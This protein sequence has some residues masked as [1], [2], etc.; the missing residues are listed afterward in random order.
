MTYNN[1]L[2]QLALRSTTVLFNFSTLNF[3]TSNSSTFLSSFELFNF[4]LLNLFS[5]LWSNPEASDRLVPITDHRP[6]LPSLSFPLELFNF[7]LL[8]LFSLLWSDA[9]WQ[10]P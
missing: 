10:I 4:E 5:L 3:S 6:S 1:P 7:E 9:T 2:D 8:N